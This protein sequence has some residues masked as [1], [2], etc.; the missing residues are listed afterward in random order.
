V[1]DLTVSAST[2]LELMR[3]ALLL[4]S[5]PAAAARRAGEILARSPS[6][7]EASLLLAAACRKLGDP[8][9]AAQSLESLPSACRETPLIQLELGRAYAASGCPAE[10]IGAFRCALALNEG[11]ADA[12]RELAEQLFLSGDTA[13]GDAAYARY[14]RLIPDPPD[15]NDAT[16]ALSSNRPDVAEAILT[17]RLGHTPHDVVALRMLADV[18]RRR[19]NFAEEERLLK[20]CLELAPG[21]MSARYDL[22][23]LLHELHRYSEVLPLVDRLLAAQPG[24]IDYLSLKAQ[25]LRLVSRNDEAIGLMQAA[26]AEQPNEHRAW[27]LCG[28]L[29]REV[30]Q[31]AQAIE[32]YRQALAVKPQSGRAYWSLANLKTF[33]FQGADIT[34]MQE[35]LAPGSIGEAD[36]TYLEFALGKALEDE[37]KFAASFEHYARG[38][39][40]HR[41]TFSYDSSSLA[42]DVQRIKALYTSAFFAD[43]HGWGSPRPDPIFIVGM[44]RS[45]STLLEQM[46]ASHSQVEGT[47]ELMDIP[48]LALEL[49]SRQGAGPQLLYPD[50]LTTL[51]RGEMEFLAER[52][53]SRTQALRPLGKARFVDKLLG[54][55]W[56]IGFIHLM[57]PHAAILDAR[58]HPLGCGFSCYK[59]LFARGIAYSYDLT[60]LGQYYRA[61]DELMEHFDTVLPGRIHRVH[62]E[63][64]VADPEGELRK[65]L[66]YCRLPFEPE[67]LRYY[68]NRRAVRTISSEQVRQPI[69]TQ[70]VDQW[71][72]YETWLEP[73]KAALGHIV[74]RYPMAPVGQK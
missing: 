14:Y 6:H 7:P 46:L 43:R 26:V 23:D 68:E 19:E 22:A 33:R 3:G 66:D 39:A 8:A 31:Q 35:Q 57:F 54:N 53:L 21:Y 47:R 65:L 61:Y 10:A 27:L 5:D 15:I 51:P 52:Y 71:R 41:A 1:I 62:Y 4:E 45:G 63:R 70:S 12:W 36:R 58:R 28:H 30:G 50:L 11:L 42:A 64:L 69:Y 24:N 74:D 20:Q 16:A 73:L 34:A 32:M 17:K 67:C 25:T 37:G 49:V 38:N 72:H 18:A 13:A 55:F 40:L 60:E 56:H 44:P 9:A 59:Q 29:L 48:A 2:D